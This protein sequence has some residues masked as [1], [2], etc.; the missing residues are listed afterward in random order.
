MYFTAVL[1]NQQKVSKGEVANIE[2]V[3]TKPL[4]SIFSSVQVY[5]LEDCRQLAKVG[6]VPT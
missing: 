4:L 5:S 2:R 6:M 3:L 1:K